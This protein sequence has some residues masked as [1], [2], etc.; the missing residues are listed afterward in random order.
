MMI[1]M[2]TMML[3]YPSGCNRWCWQ[4]QEYFDLDD[5]DNDDD[6]EKDNVNDAI[7]DYHDGDNGDYLSVRLQQMT[8]F[9]P[10]TCL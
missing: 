5:D 9:A 1:M 7:H 4:P 6:D 8:M 3:T 10:R 2:V